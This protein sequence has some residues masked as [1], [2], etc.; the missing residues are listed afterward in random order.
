MKYKRYCLIFSFS[1]FISFLVLITGIILEVKSYLEIWADILIALSS[2][3][4]SGELIALISQYKTKAIFNLNRRSEQYQQIIDIIS[5]VN[6]HDILGN[7]NLKARDIAKNLSLEKWD[8]FCEEVMKLTN[9]MR[10]VNELKVFLK[11]KNKEN[12][13]FADYNEIELFENDVRCGYTFEQKED[14]IRRCMTYI[15]N[16]Q[17]IKRFTI[18]EIIAINNELSKFYNK[19]V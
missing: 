1:F 12:F 17:A 11:I 5:K 9:I 16:L 18:E 4:I 10:R 13:K 2:G 6:K 8:Y 7:G 15:V 19:T 14:I 3:L